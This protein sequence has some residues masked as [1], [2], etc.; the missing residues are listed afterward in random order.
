MTII[1]SNYFSLYYSAHSLE[2]VGI[3]FQSSL[4][5]L[6]FF[7]SCRA[8]Q[9]LSIK[10]TQLQSKISILLISKFK[11]DRGAYAILI[12]KFYIS[13]GHL[14]RENCRTQIGIKGLF[15]GKCHGMMPKK[16][17]PV[18]PNNSVFWTTLS[19]CVY[20]ETSSFTNVSNF[21]QVFSLSLPK[22]QRETGEKRRK[23]EHKRT[24]LLCARQGRVTP[25]C[26]LL[27]PTQ[28]PPSPGGEGR[29]LLTDFQSFMGHR[30]TQTQLKGNYQSVLR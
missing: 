12:K 28:V 21:S 24:V 29:G 13:E 26:S 11:Q 2:P 9:A 8:I 5:K 6:Y 20:H 1:M 25:V 10:L 23:E 19:G 16:W 17:T 27:S 22:R 7:Q 3:D 14:Y 15:P 18:T 4:K 30:W